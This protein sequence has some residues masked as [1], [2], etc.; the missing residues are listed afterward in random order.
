VFKEGKAFIHH[1]ATTWTFDQGGPV[2]GYADDTLKPARGTMCGP[3]SI[4]S[5]EEYIAADLLADT[6]GEYINGDTLGVRWFANGSDACDAAVRLARYATHRDEFISVGYHGSSVVFATPPQNGGI[7]ECIAEDRLDVNFGDIGLLEPIV[8]PETACLI[9]EVPSM[10]EKAVGFLHLCRDLCDR[11][12]A[13][14]ILDEVVTGFRLSIGGAAE[15]YGVKPDIACY[16]KAMSN[17][18]AISAVV[19]EVS[20]MEPL[21]DRVFYSNT[22]NGDPWNL[23]YVIATLNILRQNGDAIYRHLWAIGSLLKT[24]LKGVGVTVAGHEPRTA[25]S[26]EIEEKRRAFC[27]EMIRRGIV[28]DRPQY[29]SYAHTD[30]DVYR[31]RQAAEEALEAIG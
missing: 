16:G 2:L 14:L 5:M 20:L 19:G 10:D 9:V 21:V 6:I 13:L 24:E 11:Y 30:A 22:Y 8:T 15:L 28:M 4:A 3:A 31:T 17:G 1:I 26:F 25:L 12:G 27:A 23:G 7:P 29:T 18:R